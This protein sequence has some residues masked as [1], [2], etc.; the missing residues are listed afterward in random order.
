MSEICIVKMKTRKFNIQVSYQRLVQSFIKHKGLMVEILA[1]FY[2]A[3]RYHIKGKNNLYQHKGLLSEIS[4]MLLSSIKVLC[5][6]LVQYSIN[7]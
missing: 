6:T 2:E 7:V 5:Q 3:L 4:A 1:N